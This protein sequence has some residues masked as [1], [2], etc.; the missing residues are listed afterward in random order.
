MSRPGDAVRS[1]GVVVREGSPDGP[2]I[3][4]RLSVAARALD[5][6]LEVEAD[7]LAM[8]PEGTAVFDP[9]ADGVP[10]LVVSLGGDGTL[11][12]ASRLILG[13]GVP[14]LGI[15]LGHL[16][17]LTAAGQQDLEAALDRVVT[18]EYVLEPRFTVQTEVFGADG[19]EV[20]VFD[21][22]NDVVVHKAGA[23]RVARL[24]ILVGE[25]GAEEEV[26]SFSGDGIIVATPTGSTAY[27]L[28]AG[29][30][31]VV[32]T[33]ECLTVTPI[34]PFTFAVRPLVVPST[35]AVVVRPLEDDPSLVLTLDGQD[36]RR[37]A[38]GEW[39]RVE[40]GQAPL[41]LV[42]FHGSTFFDTLRRK[43]KW[44]ARPESGEE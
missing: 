1:L 32:P 25:A 30:P 41:E 16:G 3:L 19:S 4:E 17:F 37:L 2:D 21:A 42:R 9:E 27:N 22:L 5:L 24:E 10:D 44:A 26:G 8:A 13:R 34:C 20:E 33:M 23:A 29:G 12:R 6:E 31:I 43:L 7:A 28:S 14:L 36:G 15:N 35:D 39:V 18:G 11:L 40:R 38:P